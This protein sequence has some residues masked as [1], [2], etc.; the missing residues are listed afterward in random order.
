MKPII[1]TKGSFSLIGLDYKNYD[2][3]VMGTWEALS[4][5]KIEIISII[6]GAV[7]YGVS[8]RSAEGEFCYFAGFEW[9]NPWATV[10]GSF[11]I[12]F[13]KTQT[14]AIFTHKGNA[15]SII[16]TKNMIWSTWLSAYG[17]TPMNEI[18]ESYYPVTIERFDDRF[19]GLDNEASEMEIWI[20]ILEH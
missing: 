15:S 20:P 12:R 13:L 14:Y 17:L 10:P 16:D 9:A 19:L 3:N 2:Y 11:Q 5:S 1:E 6:D 8:R 7:S 4:N 18:I